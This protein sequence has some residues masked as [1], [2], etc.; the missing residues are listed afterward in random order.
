MKENTQVPLLVPLLMASLIANN[1]N[2][3]PAKAMQITG[4]IPRTLLTTMRLEF[5]LAFESAIVCFT[6]Y[7]SLFCYLK[8]IRLMRTEDQG[9]ERIIYGAIT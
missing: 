5:C 6:H 4:K 7:H 2:D 8:S 1:R 9:K 3:D